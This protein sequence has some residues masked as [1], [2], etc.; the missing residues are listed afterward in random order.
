MMEG[1]IDLQ[2]SARRARPAVRPESGAPK[3]FQVMSGPG[4]AVVP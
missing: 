4:V 1:A 2:G 3:G